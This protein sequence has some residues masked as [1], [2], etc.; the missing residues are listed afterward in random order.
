MTAFAPPPGFD[1]WA[2]LMA[3]A[4]A[5]ARAAGDAG[6]VPVGAALYGP[7]GSLL[8]RAH[9]API[10]LNDPT[11]HAEMRVLRLAAQ[12]LGNYRLEGCVLAVTLEPCLMCLGAMVHA[13]VAGLVFGARDPKT[14]A[15]LSQLEGFALPVLAEECSALLRDFFA[16]RRG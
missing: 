10:T 13:R 2:E 16:A 4:L 1:D 8:A 5:E 9:N 14:G 3:P 11:A 15:A 6:E 7:D 12:A